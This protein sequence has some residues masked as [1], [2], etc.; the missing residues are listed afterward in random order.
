[1]GSR[2]KFVRERGPQ[3]GGGPEAPRKTGGTPPAKP[4]P[5]RHRRTEGARGAAR[6]RRGV[7]VRCQQAA[8][9]N[10]I[11]GKC[12]GDILLRQRAV[13]H[14]GPAPVEL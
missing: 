14:G 4:A 8:A 9:G 5:P 6:G 13:A 1:L 11:S 10:K 12:E 3:R 7:R 2:S